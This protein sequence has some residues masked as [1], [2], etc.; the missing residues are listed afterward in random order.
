MIII[1]AQIE[2]IA[3][4]K[5][6]TILIRFGTQELAPD[7]AA[8]LFGMGSSLCYVA[9]KAEDFGTVEIEHLESMEAELEKPGTSKAQRLRAVLFRY[10]EMDKQGYP[11]FAGFYLAKMEAITAHYK[12]KLP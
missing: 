3:T 9:I 6:G 10:W 1:A 11:D 2:G 4:R 5:D 12:A 8:E 7:K